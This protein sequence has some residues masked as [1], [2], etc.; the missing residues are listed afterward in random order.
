MTRRRD[1]MGRYSRNR[2]SYDGNMIS[3]LRNLMEEAPDER[4]KQEFKRFIQKM[5]SM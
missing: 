1:D 5:E 4:T 3:E 2:Y